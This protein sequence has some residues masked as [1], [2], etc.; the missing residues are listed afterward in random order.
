M[1]EENEKLVGCLLKI[2]IAIVSIKVVIIGLI[3][4][5]GI[6]GMIGIL[7]YERL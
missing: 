3:V 2:A 6:I 7:I 5:G 1:N 4:I